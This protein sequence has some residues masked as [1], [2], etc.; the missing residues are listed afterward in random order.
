MTRNRISLLLAAGL[1]LAAVP[2]AWA[3]DQVHVVP[4]EGSKD[5]ELITGRIRSLS[6]DEVVIEQ[7]GV[8]VPVAVNEIRFI[9]FED[10]PRELGDARRRMRDG[11]YREALDILERIQ[12]DDVKRPEAKTEVQYTVMYCRGQLALG[13]GLAAADGKNPL[14]ETGKELIK[15]LTDNPR[16]YHF[17]EANELVGNLLVANGNYSPAAAYYAAMKQAKWAD[18]KLRATVA[19]GR[20]LLAQGRTPDAAKA[21]DEAISD[22]DP[23]ELAEAQKQ[24]AKIGKARCQASS[25]RP[26]DAVKA[27]QEIIANADSANSDLNAQAYNALGAALRI[28]KKP[29]EAVLAFLHTD[30]LYYKSPDTHAEA[31]AN[32]AALFD[33]LH[34]P[35]HAQGVRETLKR[36]Y[37]ASRWAQ[38]AR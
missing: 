36:Q 21:F 9:Q 33:E 35:K 3:I 23:G 34:K 26:D 17:Y 28:A 30:L 18:Y 27:I 19:M 4:K 15:F 25:G 10:E 7:R 12:A 37:G 6:P 31:L 14:V 38:Q 24:L 2:A 16:T 1:W 8:G 32:L 22:P 20:A 29:K 11:D 13:G 5:K